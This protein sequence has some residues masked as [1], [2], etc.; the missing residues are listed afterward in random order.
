MQVYRDV[1]EST[2]CVL[3]TQ[4]DVAE[5]IISELRS[6]L[7]NFANIN[8]PMTIYEVS[9]HFPYFNVDTS[10]FQVATV[11]NNFCFK[12]KVYSTYLD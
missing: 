5:R 2:F 7:S 11:L 4:K 3:C 6:T 1:D 12:I 10:I 8:T 9:S